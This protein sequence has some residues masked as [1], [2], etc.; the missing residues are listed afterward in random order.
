MLKMSPLY[1]DPLRGRIDDDIA[2]SVGDRGG[3][4]HGEGR[5][6]AGADKARQV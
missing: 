6:A 4:R 3:R 5:V 2:A 1:H